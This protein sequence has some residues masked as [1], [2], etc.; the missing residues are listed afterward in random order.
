M[1]FLKRRNS[2][3]P[4]CELQERQPHTY[5]LDDSIRIVK[6]GNHTHGND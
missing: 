2:T 1:P 3:Q 4:S 5:I 6:K